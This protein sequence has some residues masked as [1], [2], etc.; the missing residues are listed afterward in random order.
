MAER[1]KSKRIRSEIAI[2]LYQRSDPSCYQDDAF[3][4]RKSIVIKVT[5]VA[6]NG[7]TAQF[8]TV[9]RTIPPLQCVAE[10]AVKIGCYFRSGIS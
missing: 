7:N 8:G 4:E 6:I 10:P 9:T 2:D 1:A 3:Q 5:G